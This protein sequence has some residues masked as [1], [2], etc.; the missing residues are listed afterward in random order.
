MVLLLVFFW[1]LTVVRRGASILPDNSRLAGFNSRLDR[2]E[3]PVRAATGIP[4]QGLDFL[5]SFC[6]ETAVGTGKSTKFP[7]QRE[8]PGTLEGRGRSLSRRRGFAPDP[9]PAA[10]AGALALQMLLQPWHQLDEVARPKAVVELVHEDPLPG[11]T[12]GAR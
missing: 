12:A 10:G 5:R 2:R 11:V 4:W 3:F 8:K 6:G 9:P 1:C 7:A